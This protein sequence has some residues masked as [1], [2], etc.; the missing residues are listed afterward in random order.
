MYRALHLSHNS[1]L[2]LHGGAINN[3]QSILS[4]RD[5]YYMPMVTS[6]AFTGYMS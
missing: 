5:L 2:K 1:R 4:I 6:T 3:F